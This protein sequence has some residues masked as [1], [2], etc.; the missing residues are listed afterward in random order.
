MVKKKEEKTSGGEFGVI[1]FVF[2][3]LSIVF[4]ASNG[5]ILAILGFIFST[6]QQ[7]RNPTKFGRLGKILNI[8]GFILGVILIILL[9]VFAEELTSQLGNFPA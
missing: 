1:G 9:L 8:I 5:I 6:M 2:G 3:I 7:K 4:L